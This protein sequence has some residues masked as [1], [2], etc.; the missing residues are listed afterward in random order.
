M[1]TCVLFLALIFGIIFQGSTQNL[2]LTNSA[3]IL[4]FSEA[5][6]EN[7][8]AESKKGT[9]ILNIASKEIV[10][11][12]PIT[13]FIFENGLMQEHF[14]ESY[15]ESEKFPFA[16]FSGKIKEDHDFTK[17]GEYKVSA[18]GKLTV[19]G[20]SVER[21]FDGII[22]V[23]NGKIDLIAEFTMPV[24]DHK[25]DIPNDKLTNISQNINVKIKATYEPKK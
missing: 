1:K 2:Y 11:K 8:Q 4:F 12:I 3:K 17:V 25:I 15:M 24:A 19:H 5:R 9:S 22:I 21:N 23:T 13:S 7:I 14:N 10:F 18:V 16:T 6:L 20:V